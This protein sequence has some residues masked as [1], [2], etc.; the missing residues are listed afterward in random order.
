MKLI[1]CSLVLI[2]V[3]MSSL[4]AEPLDLEEREILDLQE[5]ENLDLDER[6]TLDLEEREML[7]L[8]ER[9]NLDLEERNNLDLEQRHH[10]E[11]HKGDDSSQV[12]QDNP[13]DTLLDDESVGKQKKF[14]SNIGKVWSAIRPLLRD[15]EV[16]S[17]DGGLS[18][19][20]V[21]EDDSDQ[22]RQK[23]IWPI[24]RPYLPYRIPL[25]FRDDEVQ[26]DDQGLSEDQGLSRDET[27]SEDPELGRQKKF[28]PVLVSAVGAAAGVRK[29]IR[30][31]RKDDAAGG[32]TQ[33][34]TIAVANRLPG[35]IRVT[36]KTKEKTLNDRTLQ[37]TEALMFSFETSAQRLSNAWCKV[38]SGSRKKMFRVYGN[39]AP[40]WSTVIYNVQDSGIYVTNDTESQTGVLHSKW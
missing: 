30:S 23:K 12:Q 9:D 32:D 26:S 7:D 25:I 20:Q 39:G 37:S 36:C 3:V 33:L 15:D 13:D 35:S 14:W 21:L 11:S 31:F 2:S 38:T 40:K 22:N 16:Q 1:L 17:D 34:N 10:I 6:D 24:L 5:R 18:E 29:F 28:F 8:E 4:L 19:D 27:L